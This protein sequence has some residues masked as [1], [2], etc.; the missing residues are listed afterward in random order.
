LAEVAGLDGK[1]LP[2]RSFA[3]ASPRTGDL[4]WVF[5]DWQGNEDLG[6]AKNMPIM[7]RFRMDQ[8]QLFGLEFS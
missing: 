2:G 4:H 1:P 8:A 5:L 6:H 7:L 3:E